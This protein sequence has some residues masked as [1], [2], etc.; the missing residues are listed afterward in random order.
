MTQKFLAFLVASPVAALCLT[1]DKQAAE[2]QSPDRAESVFF[3]ELPPVE[4]AT[5]H[6]QDLKDAPA[7]VT[8]VTRRQIRRFGYRTLAEVL[9]HVRGF[10]ISHDSIWH[11]AGVRGFSLPGDYNS[12]VL[13]MIN[14]HPLTDNVYGAMYMFGQDFGLD[15]DLVERIEIIRGPSSALYGSNGVFA[16]I[17]I[18]TRSPVDMPQ[19]HV[20]LELGSFGEK[21]LGVV[22]S[23]YLGAGANLLV[24]VSGFHSSGRSLYLE[25][26]DSPESSFG[27]TERAGAEQGYHSFAQLLWRDWSFAAYFNERKGLMPTGLFWAVF[28]DPGNFSRDGRNF[29]EAVW[30]RPVGDAAS[31]RWRIS[32][33]QF[34]YR[35]RYDYAQEDG[36]VLDQRDE[37]LGD[38]LQT[39][40]YYRFPMKA[41]GDFTLGGE[42]QADL[43]SLQR[44]YL[45]APAFEEQLHVGRRDVSY[46]VFA[47][48]EWR[49]RRTLTLYGGLR[50]DDS[51]LHRRY[52]SPRGALIWRP[53]SGTACKLMYG[54]AFR[55]P[56]A[57]EMF[58]QTADGVYLSNPALGPER[59]RTVEAAWEQ[60]LH[61][62]LE[63]EATLYRYRLNDLIGEAELPTGGLQFRNQSEARA[64][65]VEWEIRARPADWL[66]SAASVSWQRA[67]AGAGRQRLVNSPS[68]LAQWRAAVPVLGD[69]LTFAAAISYWSPRLDRAGAVVPGAV[70]AD[71]T[72]TTHRLH[73]DFELQFGIRNLLDRRYADPLSA[74]HPAVRMPRPG[75]SA[76]FK[77]IWLRGG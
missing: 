73:R 12:R 61:S 19:A 36:P 74:E 71:L 69:R 48:Q 2:A 41:L 55:N 38:W 77:L 46:A 7:N 16:T 11:Y 22:S 65:G 17:N 70:V 72:A 64:T 75:R 53:G 62:R 37:A 13:V 40:L 52:M 5:L 39:Q 27:R 24:A 29:F 35:A 49:L 32:Y 60:K 3:Q 4:A 47:Q 23:A 20:S 34:R 18:V 44:T 63:M 9:S 30:N 50:L 14:G 25:E 51:R 1:A 10:Y 67:R 15:M 68:T 66:E 26:L 8:I 56:S 33:D 54:R 76:F 45:A 28:G 43:R 59:M 42:T 6:A 21:K 58:Y 31:L 57:Y